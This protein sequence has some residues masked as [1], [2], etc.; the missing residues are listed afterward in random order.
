MGGRDACA[1]PFARQSQRHSSCN[2]APVATN[3][4]SVAVALRFFPS[5]PFSNPPYPNPSFPGTP[6]VRRPVSPTQRLPRA[7]CPL[8]AFLPFPS[9]LLCSAPSEALRPT[10]SQ[11]LPSADGRRSRAPIRTRHRDMPRHVPCIP[12]SPIPRPRVGPRAVFHAP[13]SARPTRPEARRRPC[14]SSFPVH[15]S[16]PPASLRRAESRRAHSCKRCATSP[17]S[18]P[19]QA[20]QQQR[21]ACVIACLRARQCD[22]D[23]PS[24]CLSFLWVFLKR[25]RQSSASSLQ[26]HGPAPLPPLLT[27]GQ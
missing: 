7:A 24:L 18:P 3:L 13:S 27:P 25:P 8:T 16:G 15:F 2:D 10:A 23:A 22:V 17:L 14:P 5:L 4:A 19:H 1:A 9:P 20:R 6:R 21:R 11:A 26:M 12:H